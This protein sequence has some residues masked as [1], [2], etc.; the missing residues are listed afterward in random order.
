MASTKQASA[1]SEL[2]TMFAGTTLANYQ[3]RRDTTWDQKLLDFTTSKSPL[4]A[5]G[6]HTDQIARELFTWTLYFTSRCVIAE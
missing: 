6:Y 5:M 4:A 1:A 3:A 2:D